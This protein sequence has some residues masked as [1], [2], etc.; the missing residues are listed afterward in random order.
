MQYVISYD[1]HRD[2][3]YTPIWTILGQWGAQRILE[4][5]WFVTINATVGQIREALRAKTRNE[6]SL[7]II[8]LQPG[9]QWATYNAQ[10]GGVNWLTDHIQRYQ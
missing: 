2:R 5:V 4:S 10:A 8:E 9:S 3:D 1:Q 7:M 6:D